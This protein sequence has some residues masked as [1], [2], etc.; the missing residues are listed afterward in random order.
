MEKSIIHAKIALSKQP[1]KKIF[2][3]QM[4]SVRLELTTFGLVLLNSSLSSHTM[5]PTL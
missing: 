2:Q 5:R 4:S 1:K 3:K